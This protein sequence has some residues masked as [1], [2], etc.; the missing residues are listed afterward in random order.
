MFIKL[1]KIAL[2]LTIIQ[3]LMVTSNTESNEFT[4]GF[5]EGLNV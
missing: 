1:L 4:K 5:F 3:T 2:M